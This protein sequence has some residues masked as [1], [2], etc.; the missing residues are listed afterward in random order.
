M[1]AAFIDSAGFRRM[2]ASTQAEWRRCAD[3]IRADLGGWTR[4]EL[5]ADSAAGRI[6]DWRDGYQAT[7]RKAD[8]LM[9]VLKAILKHAR[10]RGWTRAN[11]TQDIEALY[12]TDRSEVVWAAHEIDEVCA[13]LMPELARAIRFIWLTGL[14][15]GDAVTALWSAIDGDVMTIATRKSKGKTKQVIEIEAELRALL[16]AT[17]RRAVTILT[18]RHGTP[19]TPNA[20]THA[21]HMRLA[22]IRERAPDFAAGKRLH[23]MRGSR[24]TEEVAALLADPATRLR[25]GWTAGKSSAPARYVSPVTALASARQKRQKDGA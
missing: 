17:P 9:T 22:K 16:D 20:I 24:A 4:R 7:P 15:R 25:M 6:M 10:L 19:Y 11:P 18:T 5:E 3:T 13:G 23:D 14:R 21:L 2:A 8:Y 12:S 1:A